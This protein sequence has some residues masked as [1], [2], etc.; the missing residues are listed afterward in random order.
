V[1][2]AAITER[3][4]LGVSPQFRRDV[5]A[6]RSLDDRGLPSNAV[7]LTAANVVLLAHLHPT[8]QVIVRSLDTLKALEIAWQKAKTLEAVIRG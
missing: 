7:S 8:E 2:A 3:L 5:E 1:N 4:W 6:A